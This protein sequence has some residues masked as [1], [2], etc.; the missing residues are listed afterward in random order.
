LDFCLHDGLYKLLPF[1]SG[2]VLNWFWHRFAEAQTNGMLH[3]YI[4]IQW[5]NWKLAFYW[6]IFLH[7][8]QSKRHRLWFSTKTCSCYSTKTHIN[9]VI[10]ILKLNLTSLRN[11]YIKMYVVLNEDHF[12]CICFSTKSN[13]ILG[14][15]SCCLREFSLSNNYTVFVKNHSLR[16]FDCTQCFVAQ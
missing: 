5:E 2:A 4:N 11:I 14:W 10:L 6:S 16:T 3:Q 1:F 9:S 12:Y 13:S 8:I 15:G 7:W